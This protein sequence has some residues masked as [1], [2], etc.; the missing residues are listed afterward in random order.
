[1][2]TGMNL[3]A[4]LQAHVAGQPA[5]SPLTGVSTTFASIMR[6]SAAKGLGIYDHASIHE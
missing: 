2:L 1:V 4:V 5:P 3:V 6:K